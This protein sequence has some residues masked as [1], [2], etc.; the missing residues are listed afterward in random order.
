MVYPF[1]QKLNQ[2]GLLVLPSLCFLIPI[3]LIYYSYYI[4][5]YSTLLP[6]LFF[7]YSFS[8][9]SCYPFCTAKTKRG[10][11][12][13]IN[14]SQIHHFPRGSRAVTCSD[15]N[16]SHPLYPLLKF[17]DYNNTFSVLTLTNCIYI[18]ITDFCST[19]I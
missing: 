17:S 7:L 19:F 16:L 15:T 10:F 12:K 9:I 5:L 13:Q 6:V 1:S 3:F 11:L 4:Y 2:N 14:D 8:F 18:Q